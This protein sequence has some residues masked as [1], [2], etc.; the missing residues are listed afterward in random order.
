MRENIHVMLSY[1]EHLD[2]ERSKCRDVDDIIGELILDQEL[3]IL[4]DQSGWS[5]IDF[6]RELLKAIDANWGDGNP[7][8]RGD[9]PMYVE[10]VALPERAGIPHW[11]IVHTCTLV[12]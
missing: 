11:K 9:Y 12:Q 6:D 1:I 10:L 8:P 5:R 7:S 4:F 3:D 2:F